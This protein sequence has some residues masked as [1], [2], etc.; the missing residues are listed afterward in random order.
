MLNK[1]D[2][3]KFEALANKFPVAK[4]AMEA[5]FPYD[6]D[7]KLYTVLIALNS[8][9]VEV[10]SDLQQ[11]KINGCS[12]EGNPAIRSLLRELDTVMF[13]AIEKTIEP[14]ILEDIVLLQSYVPSLPDRPIEYDD[15][16]IVSLKSLDIIGNNIA[17]FVNE[18]Q[19]TT[20]LNRRLFAFCSMRANDIQE[21]TRD[22][23]L[24]SLYFSNYP[25]TASEERTEIDRYS[26]EPD[27]Q[28]SMRRAIN[29]EPIV[30]TLKQRYQPYLDRC[31]VLHKE[32]V[33]HD[34]NRRM[35]LSEYQLNGDLENYLVE[36]HG[37]ENL[38]GIIWDTLKNSIGGTYLRL[39]DK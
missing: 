39:F 17:V 35:A 32:G 5:I 21:V 9:Y 10:R 11:L 34:E 2:P 26:Y 12:F 28:N 14:P 19:G 1:G 7:L 37:A 18:S 6:I 23:I 36:I 25:L 27:L 31:S 4:A 30:S 15:E 22:E 20:D 29:A 24:K 8:C 38:G 13:R 16:K 33:Q 3:E